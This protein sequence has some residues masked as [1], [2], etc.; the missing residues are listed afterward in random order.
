[1]DEREELLALRR[2]AELESKA[3][4]EKPPATLDQRVATSAPLRVMRGMTDALDAG[5]QYLPWALGAATGAFGLAPNP[6]SKFFFEQSDKVSQGITDREKA[7]QDAR[8]A[9]GQ[10]GADIAR[11]IGNVAS[12]VNAALTMA[13]G[14]AMPATMLGRAAVGGGMGGVS[15]LTTPVVNANSATLGGEKAAQT[16]AGVATGAVL[17]PAIGA[18]IDKIGPV[19]DRVANY[20]RSQFMGGRRTDPAMV[21]QQ[22]RAELGR[23]GV[24]FDDIPET[25]RTK[26]VADVTQA[27]KGGTKVDAAAAL[28]KADIEA[29]GGKPTLGMVARDPAQWTREFNLR[30]VENAGEPLMQAFQ[31]NRQ[32]VGGVFDK[33]GASK[34]QD[35]YNASSTLERIL[36]KVD[37]PKKAAVD[38][39]Y[40][41]ARDSS[42]RY[43]QLDT[44]QFIS[45]ANDSLDEMMLGGFLPSKARTMLNDVAKGDIPFNVNTMVQMR[46][47]LSGYSRD[48]ERQGDKQGALAVNKVIEALA[49]TGLAGRAA[50][51]PSNGIP[52][53]A[54]PLLGDSTPEQAI[55]AFQSAR[56]KAAERFAQFKAVPALEAAV[57]GKADPDKFVQK[58]VIGANT[59]EAKALSAALPEEGRNLVR[60]QIAAHLEQKAFGTNVTGDANMAVERYMAELER[61]GRDKLS[62]FF[63]KPEIDALY[64]AGRVGAYMGKPPAG[65]TPNYSGTAAAAFNLLQRVKGA[66]V[67]LPFIKGLETQQ[68]VR[69]S[70]L[71]QPPSEAL[72]VISPSLRGL[73]STVPV[74]AGLLGS[75]QVQ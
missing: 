4:Q 15:A 7:Y 9:T 20:M 66:S 61:M 53:V 22:V 18:V 58:F 30:G 23:E 5:A 69:N 74:G 11:G 71:A 43:A 50:N 41:A 73:L 27:L 32:A 62:A 17:T 64:Q 16:A 12:P 19:A 10:S 6:V 70:L 38:S 29:L 26:V 3:R 68:F 14:G 24:N 35:A 34:A 56:E 21:V 25:I 33:L 36:Q 28:R 46:S 75:A 1:M 63:T 45:R 13:T 54:R 47:V 67:T 40:Q 48:L 55:Q 51:T 39:A 31:Q 2:M 42:G 65:S 60:Q 37:A 44:Q 72:P 8:A 59:D 49:N 52:I 57:N